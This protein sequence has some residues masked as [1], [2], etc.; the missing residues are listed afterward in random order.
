MDATE[1]TVDHAQTAQ[2]LTDKVKRSRNL[3]TDC[4]CTGKDGMANQGE[5]IGNTQEGE[6]NDH[7]QE[8]ERKSSA[9][10]QHHH[11]YCLTLSHSEPHQNY[12]Q[13]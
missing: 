3:F 4:M 10:Y 13:L 9:R 11:Y 12:M 1:K 2:I 5:N 8:G 7:T 6:Q